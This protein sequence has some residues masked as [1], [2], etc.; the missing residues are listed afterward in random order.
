MPLNPNVST[1]IHHPRVMPEKFNADSS[2][3]PDDWLQ[4]V[5]IYKYAYRLSDAQLFL[6]LPRLLD[7]EPEKWFSA[8]QPHLKSW[9]QF[10][11]LFHLAF[12]PVDN[13]EMIWRGI[14]DRVR[15]RAEPLPTIVTHLVGEFKKIKNPPP[16]A[17]KVEIIRRH[18]SDRY[19]LAL[20]GC[21]M[22]S[23]ADLL[24]K[25]HELHSVL[26][27]VSPTRRVSVLPPS[28]RQNLRCFNCSAPGV[29]TRNCQTYA[30]SH[31]R[32]KAQE[33]LDTDLADRGTEAVVS[34]M[35][36]DT[37]ETIRIGTARLAQL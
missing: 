8:T 22:T 28:P 29:T 25:A 27:P 32:E 16:E 12:L 21:T 15:G 6:E 7:K 2:I 30:E 36:Q 3:Q 5:F 10:T 14:L 19:K 34:G 1:F 31:Y 9:E 35:R 37:E 23:I 17:D 4:S 20:Y 18:V 26:G 24:L 13:Q 11:E 33:G